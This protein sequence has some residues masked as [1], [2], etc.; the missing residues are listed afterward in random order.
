MGTSIFQCTSFFALNTVQRKTVLRYVQTI[1]TSHLPPIDTADIFQD[2]H[3]LSLSLDY[4]D[5]KIKLIKQFIS[6][7]DHFN[8]LSAERWVMLH[9]ELLLA[10]YF[11]CARYQLDHAQRLGDVLADHAQQIRVCAAL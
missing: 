2:Q 5:Y 8:G 7:I 11:F 6:V 3:A 9:D 10:F 1:E 4:F